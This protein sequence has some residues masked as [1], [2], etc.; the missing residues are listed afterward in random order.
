[1]KS[2]AAV[3]ITT[4]A[5]NAIKDEPKI[6]RAEALRRSIATL[7]AKGGPFA[8]PSVWAPFVLVGDG[9]Q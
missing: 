6:G 8:H 7:I 2:D 3:A 4:G 9:E 5:V 1:V